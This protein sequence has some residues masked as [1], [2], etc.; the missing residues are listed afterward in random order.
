MANV[1][2]LLE[3]IANNYVSKWNL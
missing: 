1:A 3:F 2:S